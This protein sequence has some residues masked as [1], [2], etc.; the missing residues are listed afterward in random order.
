MVISGDMLK[1][2][3][4]CEHLLEDITKHRPLSPDEM[5]FIKYYCHEL[6]SKIASPPDES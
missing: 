2:A 6:L 4:A 1:F 3:S 5:V